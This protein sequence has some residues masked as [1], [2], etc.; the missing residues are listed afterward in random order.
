MAR[1]GGVWKLENKRA[2]WDE[3]KKKRVKEVEF[4]L[5]LVIYKFTM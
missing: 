4:I 1:R 5:S 3:K 2:V